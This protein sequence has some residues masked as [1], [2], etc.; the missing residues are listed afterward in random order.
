MLRHHWLAASYRGETVDKNKFL[1]DLSVSE[2]TDFGR[3]DFA[4][5]P[6]EQKVF[7]AIWRLESEI[8]NGGFL[9]YFENDGGETAGFA[10]TALRRIG[11]NRCAAIVERALNALGEGSLPLDGQGWEL[12]IAGISDEQG[13][14][15]DRLDAEFFKYPDD[16]TE[17]LFQFVSKHQKVFGPVGEV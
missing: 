8:N 4:D 15:L 10:V 14:I 12:L 6:E 9:Q 7:S 13:E 2:H 16:L 17:L 5:Q 1:V 11:A 3:V